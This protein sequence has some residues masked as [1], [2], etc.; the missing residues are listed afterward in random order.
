MPAQLGQ[1]DVRPSQRRT[2]RHQREEQQQGQH[3]QRSQGGEHHAG[4]QRALG[5]D[6]VEERVQLE[7]LDLAAA[8]DLEQLVLVGRGDRLGVVHRGEVDRTRVDRAVDT[9]AEG[10]RH[11]RARVGEHGGRGGR[12][13][14]TLRRW[15]DEVLD[16]GEP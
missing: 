3:H 1:G 9:A 8:A 4:Q 5:A 14:L 13:R 11:H 7:L 16:D 10:L 15:R 6:P 2:G 12:G